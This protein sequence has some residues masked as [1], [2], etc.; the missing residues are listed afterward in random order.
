MI[1]SVIVLIIISGCIF[2]YGFLLLIFDNDL[3]KGL[4]VIILSLIFFGM[5]I[6]MTDDEK[7]FKIDNLRSFHVCVVKYIDQL[8]LTEERCDAQCFE[9]YKLIEKTC[10]KNN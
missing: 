3:E 2:S 6:F 8:G 9:Q 10:K 1:S 4:V 5:A 7:D